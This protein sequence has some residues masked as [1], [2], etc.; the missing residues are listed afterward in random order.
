MTDLPV[1]VEPGKWLYASC[2]A[3][4]FRILAVGKDA[5]GNDC[6]TISGDDINEFIDDGEEIGSGEPN[7]MYVE[8]EAFIL[9]DVPWKRV[10]GWPDIVELRTPGT[11]C[12]RCTKSFFV[13]HDKK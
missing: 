4:S 2:S 9:H 6:M 1:P 10:E 12:Y 8:P 13:K 3:V 7:L 11:G 5:N